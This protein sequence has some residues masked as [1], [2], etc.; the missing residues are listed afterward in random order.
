MEKV[1]SMKKL[2]IQ[3]QYLENYAWNEDGSLGTGV[4]AYWKPKGGSTYVMPNCGD[5]DL[6]KIEDLVRPLICVCNDVSREYIISSEIVDH[7][8]KVCEDWETVTQFRPMEDGSVYFMKVTDNREDGWMRSE[9]LEKIETWSNDRENYKAEYLMEDG[10]FCHSDAEL[11]EWFD[12]Q[13]EV[14]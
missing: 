7:N 8:E 5:A 2:V 13:N 4:D 12:L 3:T 11:R 6:S 14:A 10:D 9:I 1:K